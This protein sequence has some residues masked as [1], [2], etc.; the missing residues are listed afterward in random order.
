MWVALIYRSGSFACIASV[1]RDTG[2]WPHTMGNSK[3]HSQ[4]VSAPPFLPVLQ[5]Q[6]QMG[7][8][9]EPESHIA[10][11]GCCRRA[12]VVCTQVPCSAC[13][14]D[15]A[16]SGTGSLGS[17]TR[18]HN[19]RAVHRAEVTQMCPA[20]ERC[21]ITSRLIR[22]RLWVHPR[23]CSPLRR[24]ATNLHQRT[25]LREPPVSPSCRGQD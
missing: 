7:T 19:T 11:A 17:L 25:S 14:F 9:G 15:A 4:C 5:L 18:Q 24:A 16:R 21:L 20:R 2:T 23:R 3:R 22:G 10:V 13:R 6:N 1:Q 8:S 12:L